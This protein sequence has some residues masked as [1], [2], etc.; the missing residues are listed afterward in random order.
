[1]VGPKLW[2]W[3][4]IPNIMTLNKSCIKSFE[5]IVLSC[6][7]AN[8]RTVPDPHTLLPMTWSFRLSDWPPISSRAFPVAATSGIHYHCMSP[9]PVLFFLPWTFPSMTSQ[10]S[11]QC[12]LPLRPL[13]NFF[14]LTDCLIEYWWQFTD[15]L[16][17]VRSLKA[18]LTTRCRICSVSSSTT[19]MTSSIMTT[20]DLLR[21]TRARH[22][23]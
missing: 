23:S 10:W 12:L 5:Y 20:F 11:L 7:L 8:W 15:R 1:M 21:T 4:K 9:L 22:S 14:W 3:L 2:C 17:T 13:K 19:V 18:V 16:M 6:F